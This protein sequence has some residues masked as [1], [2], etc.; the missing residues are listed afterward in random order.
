MYGAPRARATFGRLFRS[1]VDFGPWITEVVPTA[2]GL[3]IEGVEALA[4]RAP[5]LR[6]Q[7]LSANVLTIVR[8]AQGEGLSPADIQEVLADFNVHADLSAIR[9]ALRRWADRHQIIKNGHRY[10][11][12]AGDVIQEQMRAAGTQE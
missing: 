1:P 3:S 2:C 7:N 12:P 8:Q 4:A 9:Q 10:H 6:E 5:E 11:A